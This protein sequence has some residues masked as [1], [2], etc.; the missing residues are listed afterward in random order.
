MNRLLLLLLAVAAFAAHADERILD[1]NSDI[2][3]LADGSMQVTETIRVR[4]E[5]NA[6]KRGIYRDFPTDYRDRYGNRYHVAFDVTDV[7]RDGGSEDSHTE[8]RANGVR[9]Y[10]GSAN[11]MLATGIH[12]YEIAYRTDRQLGFFADHDELYWNVTGNG[13][14]FPIDHASA[15]IH[16]PS[17]IG[18]DEIKPEGYTGY[19]GDKGSDYRAQVTEDG[20][21]FETTRPLAANEGLTIVVSWP[22]GH[23]HEPDRQERL[24][25]L[26]DDNRELAAAGGGLILLTLYYLLVW[27]RVGRDPEAGVIMPHYQPPDGFSPASM[28]FIQRMG[29]DHKTFAT[30]VVGLAVKGYLR[31]EEKADDFQVERTDTAGTAKGKLGPG[32][33]VLLDKL[34]RHGS[35][36]EFVQSNHSAISTAIDAH[37]AALQRNYEKAFFVT[38]RLYLIPGILITLITLVASVL[39][40]TPGS[41]KAGGIFMMIWL[42]GWSA[43]VVFLA[44][45]A[46]SAWRNARNTLSYASAITTTFVALP[47]LIFEFI[48]LG[49][50]FSFTSFSMIAILLIAIALN[51]LFYQLLKAPTRAGRK[52]LDRIDGFRLYLELAEGE[53]LRL[54]GAP[55]PTPQL[56][57]NYLPYAMAL[58]LEQHW[59]ERF[60]GVFAALDKRE[61][62][63]RPGW[64]RGSHFSGRTAGAFAGTLGGGFSSAIAASSTAPGSR[65]GSSSGGGG[66][67]F[68]G[69]GGGGGGGGGW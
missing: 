59:A 47:F 66:G 6:I 10:L 15:R 51:L 12:V 14:N 26:L 62:T 9:L 16:L 48:G 55:E 4:A 56:F 65:S 3:V 7:R 50:L 64:Y 23:V 41:D 1:F 37:K 36:M 68:S 22:K 35:V 39:I 33:K 30:A 2:T 46:I 19:S 38:N 25:Y 17:G 54:A 42:S 29:Y 53:E 13:W 21:F 31:I 28:R 60:S 67:G 69:G 49:V 58:N 34:F 27:A 20:A 11:R 63:Y 52:L 8:Q 18:S 32:E 5:G 45:S 40:G 44:R 24:G 61:Q 57:E 43:A